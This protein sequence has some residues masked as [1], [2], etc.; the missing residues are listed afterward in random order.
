MKVNLMKVYKETLFYNVKSINL[1]ILIVLLLCTNIVFSSCDEESDIKQ[2]FSITHDSQAKH[3]IHINFSCAELLNEENSNNILK[4]QNDK[5]KLK[6][7]I[8]ELNNYNIN[9]EIIHSTEKNL[10][11]IFKRSN[12][13]LS[14]FYNNNSPFFSS[15]PNFETYL[16]TL[17][18]TYK[19]LSLNELNQAI[20]LIK[21]NNNIVGFKF[22]EKNPWFPFSDEGKAFCR[23]QGLVT[24][25]A[26]INGLVNKLEY[27]FYPEFIEEEEDI[28]EGLK[29]SSTIKSVNFLL[30]Q[31]RGQ[32][33]INSLRIN[34]KINDIKLNLNGRNFRK[35]EIKDLSYI[36]THSFLLKNLELLVDFDEALI[37]SLA[38]SL[39]KNNSL[40]KL[41]LKF[42]R[43]IHKEK[44][45]RISVIDD[46]FIGI[47]IN[48]SLRALNLNLPLSLRSFEV[49]SR[50]LSVNKN[51]KVLNL[52]YNNINDQKT[53][54]LMEGLK[55]NTAIEMIDLSFNDIT[56]EGA[57]SIIEMLQKNTKLESFYLNNNKINPIKK[58]EI[59]KIM[60]LRHKFNI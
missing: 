43:N 23:I 12:W 25:N 48:K 13:F 53:N 59:D 20:N 47:N 15:F 1:F 27:T 52:A 37:H 19:I 55:K 50:A 30:N 24:R 35:I 4:I 10:C 21:D 49:F 40:E 8:S 46:F 9:V 28:S 7:Y 32:S 34:G 29:K 57:N 14:L 54:L 58:N 17:D 31:N 41:S 11:L 39:K 3:S 42:H 51:I 2:N 16:F 18:L 6:F 56:D 45:V 60:R 26:L 5:K 38:F 22:N 33:I 36:I 44:K